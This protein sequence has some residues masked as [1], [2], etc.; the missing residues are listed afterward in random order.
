MINF[1]KRYG[2]LFVSCILFYSCEDDTMTESKF[3]GTN[4]NGTGGKEEVNIFW[5]WVD[6]YPG[7]V[8]SKLE[9]LG[10][11]TVNFFVNGEFELDLW[12]DRNTGDTLDVPSPW[13]GP[14]L[15][16][17][18]ME[19]VT[20]EVPRGVTNLRCLV[21]SNPHFL[22]F[23]YN[24]RNP[25]PRWAD[26][27]DTIYLKP[28]KNTFSSYF[29][30][31]MYFYWED[32]TE[33]Q[34][35]GTN[36]VISGGCVRANNY[37]A[38]QT[39]Y[40]KW[41]ESIRDN[42]IVDTIGIDDTGNLIVKNSR[43]NDLEWVDMVG[44]YAIVSCKYDEF[45]DCDNPAT[46]LQAID[47]WVKS[48]CEFFAYP[49]YQKNGK[50]MPQRRVVSDPSG[51]QV[52][53]KQHFYV[54]PVKWEYRG[55]EPSR[56]LWDYEFMTMAAPR[57]RFVEEVLQAPS[58]T[59]Y[60]QLSRALDAGNFLK[61][62]IAA[63]CYNRLPGDAIDLPFYASD[64]NPMRHMP[65]KFQDKNTRL[66]GLLTLVNEIGWGVIPYCFHAA[67]A[68]HYRN[69][70]E[71][72][73]PVE[74][75]AM[76]ACEYAN[77]NL[78]G[79]YDNWGYELTTVV[80][81]Y[82]RKF[83]EPTEKWW[84][85]YRDRIAS[86]DS[87]MPPVK[88]TLTGV[89]PQRYDMNNQEK[90][91]WTIETGFAKLDARKLIDGNGRNSAMAQ[92]VNQED[93]WVEID[94]HDTLHF[95]QFAIAQA[96]SNNAMVRT[97]RLKLGNYTDAAKTQMEWEYLK[98]REGNV[99]DLRILPIKA[100]WRTDINL[101]VMCKAE[102]IRLEILDLTNF[103]APVDDVRPWPGMCGLSEIYVRRYEYGRPSPS[104]PYP[105]VPPVEDKI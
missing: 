20:V 79:F 80:R 45:K 50:L 96:N 30:G 41:I 98:D 6:A 89:G 22:G 102:K 48:Y 75:F 95:N 60:Q 85:S 57:S 21:G 99:V 62:Y 64:E 47:N 104:D 18:I 100:G 36:V 3:I 54:L 9:R 17:A 61:Y 91:N 40:N 51:G 77:M 76:H 74:R 72:G 81:D 97:V 88:S 56:G 24:Q 31:M 94:F 23:G 46:G 13:F 73:D 52:N 86:Y 7:P 26:V 93:A 11:D 44:K 2:Y 28:G 10:R 34:K 42:Y 78:E 33:P 49:V 43:S 90:G 92:K 59:R 14:G 27:Q 53:S 63:R 15:Y 67:R 35:P 66:T 69:G 65:S 101:P 71:S 5:D 38:G 84:L 87:V 19:P 82:M 16:A 8:S 103:R 68:T 105:Y 4:T 12:T 39:D 32:K 58:I 25:K 83:P 55:T 29:G 37:V 1:F 70:N